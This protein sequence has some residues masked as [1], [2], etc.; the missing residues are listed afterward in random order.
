MVARTTTGRQRRAW[1]KLRTLRSGH[2]QASYVH[3]DGRRYYAPR[4]F[5]TKMD[6]EG[7]L[8]SE[9]KLIDIDEWSPPEDRQA[10]KS[11]RSIT[12][13]EYAARWLSERDLAV[14]HG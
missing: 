7:W 9:R 10:A 13:G 2:T 8:S 6:A 14:L 11:V 1:G 5:T 12:V 3:T 4:T